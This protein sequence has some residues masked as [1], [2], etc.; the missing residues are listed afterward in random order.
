MGRL[1]TLVTGQWADLEFETICEK[2]RAMGYEG[3]ELA[4]WG[5]H[6]NVGK[7]V[8]ENSY[9]DYILATLYKHSLKMVAIG[10]HLIGQCVGDAPDPRLDGFAPAQYAGKP[11]AIRS[12][13]IEEMMVC[14]AAAKK[15]G[16]SIATSFCGSPIWRYIY[17]FPQ[18][19][20]K[21]VEE[22]FDEIVRLWGPIMDVF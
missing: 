4:C 5:K 16:V 1:L 22:G 14:A 12:W 21:M 19:T 20:T 2:A 18:T 13:A 15:L 3:L 11:E 7:V 9:A 17:S 6:L 10:T 8:N